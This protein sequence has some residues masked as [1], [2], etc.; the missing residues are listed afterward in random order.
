MSRAVSAVMA[1]LIVGVCVLLTGCAGARCR[2][3][4]TNIDQPV[5]F[6]PCVFDSNGKVITAGEGDTLKHFKLKKKSW[7]ILWRC[8]SIS[9]RSW[10]ISDPLKNEISKANGDAVVNLTVASTSDW[11][12]Y[13]SALIPI[14]PDYHSV[15]V[16]GDVVRFSGSGAAR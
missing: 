10:D 16:E 14:I 3:T 6:S 4:A 9:N 13:F 11:W 12:W 5:S 15:V 2:V 8:I 1:L 7:A